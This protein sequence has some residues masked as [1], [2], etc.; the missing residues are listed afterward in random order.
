MWMWDNFIN[1]FNN[2]V[3]LE[4]LNM[5]FKYDFNLKWVLII[6]YVFERWIL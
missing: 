4:I 2:V 3:I 1:G 5:Y 6:F